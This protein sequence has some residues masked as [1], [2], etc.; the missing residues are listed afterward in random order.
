MSRRCYVPTVVYAE[1]AQPNFTPAIYFC[2]RIFFRRKFSW[3]KNWWKKFST[4]IFF[5]P[6]SQMAF[7][8]FTNKIFNSN[9]AYEILQ[10]LVVKV[11]VLPEN[12]TRVPVGKFLSSGMELSA[13]VSCRN[14]YV[15]EFLLM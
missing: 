4:E 9:F 12:I 3:E 7:F 2:S 6:N 1:R 11:R 8:T 5:Y 13:V 10:N 14:V 15:V